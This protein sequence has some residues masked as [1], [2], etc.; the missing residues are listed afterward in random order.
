MKN[1]MCRTCI[2]LFVFL[3]AFLSGCDD[4]EDA[5]ISLADVLYQTVWDVT[6][7]VYDNED[8]IVV[9]TSSVLQFFSDSQG[10]EIRK[11][12]SGD[13]DSTWDF[14]Y[15][16]NDDVLIFSGSLVGQWLVVEYTEDRIVLQSYL[17]EK[18]VMTLEKQINAG[19]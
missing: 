3:S 13:Y 6:E 12:D 7:T 10:V 19:R 11:D 8:N 14:N 18:H 4:E 15:E 17:P 16:I 9:Q 2:C 1:I 5:K